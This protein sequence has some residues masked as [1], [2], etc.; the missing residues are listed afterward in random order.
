MPSTIVRTVGPL[1]R[2]KTQVTLADPTDAQA[3]AFGET[4][5]YR[6]QERPQETVRIAQVATTPLASAM[7]TL[8]VTVRGPRPLVHQAPPAPVPPPRPLARSRI[9]R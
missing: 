1:R 5:G 2:V 8:V 9:F 3:L 4:R 6:A 7:A